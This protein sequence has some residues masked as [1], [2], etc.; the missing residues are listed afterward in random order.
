M[1]KKK[2]TLPFHSIVIHSTINIVVYTL[3]IFFYCMYIFVSSASSLNW[4]HTLHIVLLPIFYSSMSGVP[5]P[6]SLM[7]AKYSTVRLCN[8]FLAYRN[9]L[10]LGSFTC[11]TDIY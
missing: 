6:M 1:L 7:T 2:I 9:Y 8:C 3:S 10:I 11:V 5:F 4:D